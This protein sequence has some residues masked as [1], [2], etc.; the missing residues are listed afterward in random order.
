MFMLPKSCRVHPQQGGGR[1]GGVFEKD[2]KW[3]LNKEFWE[4]RDK[5]ELYA[6]S[7]QI[8]M[9]K[10]KLSVSTLEKSLNAAQKKS[11]TIANAVQNK[12]F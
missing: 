7:V 6:V 4:L 8:V 2:G 5:S 3:E 1:E 12:V 11:K 10:I 9:E